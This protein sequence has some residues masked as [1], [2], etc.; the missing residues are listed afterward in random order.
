MNKRSFTGKTARFAS[1]SQITLRSRFYEEKFVTKG[2]RATTSCW[3]AGGQRVQ[4]VLH[5]VKDTDCEGEE[6]V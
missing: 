4:R 1:P 5:K 3:I 6:E 2:R